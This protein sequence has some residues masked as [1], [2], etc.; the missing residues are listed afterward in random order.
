MGTWGIAIFEDD[1]A[2]DIQGDYE[3]LLGAGMD[4]SAGGSVARAG[5]DGGRHRAASRQASMREGIGIAP[6]NC[7]HTIDA[8]DVKR[9]RRLLPCAARCGIL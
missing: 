1:L 7:I 5:S 2:M 4:D 8:R 3:T 6:F 9:F